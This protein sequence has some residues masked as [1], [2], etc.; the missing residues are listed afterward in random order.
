M[1]MPACRGQP[2]GDYGK[3]A[4]G[5]PAIRDAQ[6]VDRAGAGPDLAQAVPDRLRGERLAPR[7]AASSGSSPSARCAASAEECVQPEPCAAPSGWRSPGIAT[8]SPPSKNTSV[9]SSRWPPVTTTARGPSAWTARA[10]SSGVLPAAAREHARLGEVGRDHGDPRQ[11][12]VA[13]QLAARPR[14]AARRRSRPPSPGRAPRAPRRR[15]RAPRRTASI[16][17]TVPSMPI[18]TAS[19]P[20]SSATARTC[21]TIT[22]G[23]SGWTA[24]TPTVFCA[25]I[26]VMAVIPC[27]PTAGER[28][29]VGLDARAA[30]GVRAG[31]RE[32]TWRR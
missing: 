23:G 11:Q 1:A 22:S 25:V 3:G 24:V 9:A 21:S 7:L 15:G 12:P 10:S 31:D 20:M 13:Q 5:A 18:F 16:V 19:T 32:H 30:A 14:R 8:G 28:L 29:Q 17:S 26:A 4:S 2:S 27:T 6:D